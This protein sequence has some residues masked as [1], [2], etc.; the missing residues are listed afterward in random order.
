MG[1]DGSDLIKP[2]TGLE[3]QAQR[4]D[5]KANGEKQANTCDT[6]DDRRYRSD[7]ETYRPQVKV[8]WSVIVH[9]SSL[10]LMCKPFGGGWNGQTNYQA[11]LR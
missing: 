5:Q 11:R 3:A 4:P 10:L 6:V 1:Q 9:G 8:L 7:R 2:L